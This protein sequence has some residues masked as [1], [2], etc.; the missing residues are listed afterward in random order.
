ML[1]KLQ[2]GRK[3]R[4]PRVRGSYIGPSIAV[5]GDDEPPPAGARGEARDVVSGARGEPETD[6]KSPLART[7]QMVSPLGSRSCPPGGVRRHRRRP[8]HVSFQ[9]EAQSPFLPIPR[10]GP[11]TSSPLLSPD[12]SAQPMKLRTPS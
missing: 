8:L 1:S 7:G 6:A 5:S 3:N 12:P 4:R 11:S 2:A 9:P 10:S